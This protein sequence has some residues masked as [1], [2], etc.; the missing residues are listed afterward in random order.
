MWWRQPCQ[1]VGGFALPDPG[2]HL[3]WEAEH[4]VER[5]QGGPSILSAGLGEVSI[6][7]YSLARQKRQRVL[8]GLQRRGLCV[9]SATKATE[10]TAKTT[11]KTTTKTT[12]LLLLLLS[13]FLLLTLL[14]GLLFGLNLCL[15]VS[16]LLCVCHHQILAM[17]RKVNNPL[18]CFPQRFDGQDV[19]F[20]VFLSLLLGERG[21]RRLLLPLQESLVALCWT[22]LNETNGM[23]PAH[24]LAA[25][26]R[27][28]AK[29]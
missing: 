12:S 29:G 14:L 27:V 13:L 18:Q 7:F 3:G 23:V 16:F 2:I 6:D 8:L 19:K 15:S 28:G 11:A 5:Y 1:R 24:A 17:I 9:V 20:T 4:L 26:Q 25:G 21:H 10:T 22:L